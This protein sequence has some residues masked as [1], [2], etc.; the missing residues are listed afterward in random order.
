MNLY[1]RTLVFAAAFGFLQIAG[2]AYAADESLQVSVQESGYL[3]HASVSE[4]HLFVPDAKMTNFT[5][6]MRK[7]HKDGRYFFLHDE[8]RGLTLS[9]WN[10]PSRLYPGLEQFWSDL[11]ES[12]KKRELWKPVNVV[13]S[14]LGNWQTIF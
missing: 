1:F 6:R 13:T 14:K 7:S 9:G 12:W 8:K 3:L 5:D 11:S 4:L 2:L 10:E